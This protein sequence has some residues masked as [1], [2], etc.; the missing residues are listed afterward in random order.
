MPTDT[1]I[2]RIPIAGS[3]LPVLA[4]EEWL[5]YL[6]SHGAGHAW[7]SFRWLVDIGKFMQRELDWEKIEFLAKGFGMQSILHQGLILANRL[8][9]APLPPGCQSPVLTDRHAERLSSLALNLGLARADQQL[10][11]PGSDFNNYWYFVYHYQIRVGWRNKVKYIFS[12]WRPAVR[13]I[14]LISLPDP[15]YP[16]YYAIRPFTLFCWVFAR[17]QKAAAGRLGKSTERNG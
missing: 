15:L 2:K 3:S 4:D 7:F 16:L 14:R 1:S 10:R 6:I 11:E 12:L 8:L 9:E 5:L 13:D 17:S